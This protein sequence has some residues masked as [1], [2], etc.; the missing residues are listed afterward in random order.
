V[1]FFEDIHCFRNG[2]GFLLR[3]DVDGWDHLYYYTNDGKLK[4]RLTSGN[5]PVT[6]ISLVDEKGGYVYFMARPTK[7]WDSH[8]MRVRLDGTAWNN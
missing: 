8:L 7:S 2:S 6:S 3:T 1:R 4:K 5:W